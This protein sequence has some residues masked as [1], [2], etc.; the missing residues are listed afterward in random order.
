M[1]LH[2]SSFIIHHFRVVPV[3]K[4]RAAPSPNPQPLASRA[5]IQAHRP[6]RLFRV[7]RVFRG[8]KSP[9]PFGVRFPLSGRVFRGQNL[10][11]FYFWSSQVTFGH[12]WSSFPRFCH[13]TGPAKHHS[14]QTFTIHRSLFTSH[15]HHSSFIIHHFRTAAVRRDLAGF[16]SASDCSFSFAHF[17]YFAVISG[18]RFQVPGSR[19]PPRVPPHSKFKIQNSKLPIGAPSVSPGARTTK[20]WIFSETAGSFRLK[21]G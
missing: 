10:L 14:L 18:F 9:Q 15:F 4:D 13:P 11:Q 5:R 2:H 21:R 8:L 16:G 1:A 20:H 19:L 3:R 7:F 17:V 12:V 6:E